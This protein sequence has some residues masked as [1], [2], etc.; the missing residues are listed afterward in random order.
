MNNFFRK[1][2]GRYSSL[3]AA[4]LTL[5]AQAGLAQD[6]TLSDGNSVAT[7]NLA[8][9]TGDSGMNS[10]AI[11]GQN[12]LQQQWFWFRVGS[13]PS[14]QH[15][16]D[17]LGTPTVN[18][19]SGNSVDATYHGTGFDVN[20]VYVLN[21]GQTGGNDWNSDI[22]ESISIKNNTAADLNFHFFQ[23]SDF[24]LGN[25]VGNSTVQIYQ[26]GGFFSKA[27]VLKGGN[28]LSE[29]ID[30]PLADHAEAG[31]TSDFPNT[32]DELNS[33]S[34]ITLNDNLSAGPDASAD[35]TWALE[36]DPTIGAG[37]SS[38][39][40]KDKRLSVAPVPEP[41]SL[42]LFSLGLGAF[43]LRRSRRLV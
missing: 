8:G 10:W 23:Y 22:I 30:N 15:R 14:G 40:L 31:V 28:Q 34:P 36:W 2:F 4:A 20:I 32:L 21:G 38:D 17:S 35:G 16:L 6:V 33:G 27:T 43:I 37:D 42:A 7:V 41:T 19:L 12:Q 3:F 13:D 5:V 26:D 18:T 9:G 25:T 1:P 39:I 24:R 29:T 11:N